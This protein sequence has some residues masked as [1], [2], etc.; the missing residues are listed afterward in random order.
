M[1]QK[2]GGVSI[3]RKSVLVIIALAIS[4]ISAIGQE[5]TSSWTDKGVALSNQGNYNEAIKAFDEAIKLDPQNAKAWDYKGVALNA[6]GK[7]DEAVKAF[8][9][10][11]RLDPTKQKG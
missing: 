11:I 6:L 10:A 4:C 5:T 2:Y 1:V 8:D 3:K 7:Y 9:E